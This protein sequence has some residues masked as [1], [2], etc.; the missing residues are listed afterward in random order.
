MAEPRGAARVQAA[1]AA[2]GST[3]Q[4]RTLPDSTRTAAEAAA[5]LGV[6]VGAI[7]KSLVF[8][9]DGQPVLV[10]ASGADRVD[11]ER[12][13]AALRGR[14]I[15][16]ADA[17]AVRAATG[18]PIGGVS[19]A[20]LPDSLPVFV[21]QALADHR[22]VWAAA[23]TPRSVFPTT[24]DELLQITGGTSSDVRAR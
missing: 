8:L 6:E 7:A 24:Y 16:R 12:L 1:L 20:A 18:Y 3:A 4:V 13:G 22:V 15:T 11:I 19:P 14:R 17:D 5:A 9:A 10:V 21:E 2:A 23:G